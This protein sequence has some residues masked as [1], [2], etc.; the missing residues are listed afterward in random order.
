MLPPDLIR[1][2]SW[3]QPALMGRGISLCFSKG[4]VPENSRTHFETTTEL[5]L[6]I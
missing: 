1:S 2:M 3:V 4:G 5:T 6:P